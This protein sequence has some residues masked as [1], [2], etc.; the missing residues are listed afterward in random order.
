MDTPEVFRCKTCG[1]RIPRAVAEVSLKRG[2][3]PAYCAQPRPCRNTG[4]A[5]KRR[6]RK[7]QPSAADSAVEAKNG[8]P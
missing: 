5:R 2:K 6:A 7:D 3:V 8:T 4:K 1:R